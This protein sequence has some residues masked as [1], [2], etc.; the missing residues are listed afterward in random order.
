MNKPLL[1]VGA[2]VVV[3]VVVWQSG[4]LDKSSGDAYAPEINP[5]DF[6]TT[7]NNPYFTLV[8][9]TKYVFE[10][11]KPEG[12]ER[13]EV[14]VLN[15]T[16][17]IAGVPTRVVKDQ[18]FLN[19]SLIEDTLDWYAQDDDGN[20][21]Y[22]GE[23]T[24]EYENGKVT[25]THGSWEMGVNGAQPG[26]VMEANP[27]VGDTYRQEYFKGEA[28]DAADVVAVA[29]TVTVP[30]GT[31]R[32]CVQTYD[33]TPLNLKSREHK[34]YCRGVGFTTL[35]LNLEDNERTELV[36]VSRVTATATPAASSTPK[37]TGTP[38]PTPTPTPSSS[39]SPVTESQA[40]AIALARV[41]GTVTDVA[42]ETR[43]GVAVFVV[44]V[45]PSA[46]GAETDVVINKATGV[47]IAVE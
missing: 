21:W 29:Q 19:D 12:K 23:K 25:T 40:K 24:A 6:S 9:G 3:G 16:R 11:E 31:Y 10:A 27:K 44:E 32:D 2:A 17:T 22:F 18:V 39:A 20:V 47:I 35:E 37:A 13:I 8:P 38:A 4:I 14:T 7:I 15:E 33:Y 43:G 46:G 34:F 1:F 42:S 5:A 45:L 28:E 41:P 26:I 36:S 30:Y